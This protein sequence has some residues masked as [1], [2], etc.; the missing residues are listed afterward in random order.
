M[1]AK[2]LS[3]PEFLK[4]LHPKLQEIQKIA[5]SHNVKNRLLTLKYEGVN[6]KYIFRCENYHRVPVRYNNIKTR[7]SWC[8]ACAPKKFNQRRTFEEINAICMKKGGKYLGDT[9][10]T[11]K[12]KSTRRQRRGSFECH[13]G[14]RWNAL[15]NNIIRTKGGSWCPKCK[16]LPS[17]AKCRYILE[18]LF[19]EKFIKIQPNWLKYK[20]KNLELDG[21]NSELKLAFEYDGIHHTKNMYHDKM[22]Q[23]DTKENKESP[24]LKHQKA[25]DSHKNKI[26][27][28]LGIKMI[29]LSYKY[30]KG[31]SIP[32]VTKYIKKVLAEL[33]IVIPDRSN[34]TGGAISQEDFNEKF[35]TNYSKSALYLRRFKKLF[36][37]RKGKF[38]NPEQK[39]SDPNAKYNLICTHGHDF[40]ISYHGATRDDGRWCQTC[41]RERHKKLNE[42]NETAKIQNTPFKATSLRFGSIITIQCLEAKHETVIQ[43]GITLKKCPMCHPKYSEPDDEDEKVEIISTAVSPTKQKIIDRIGNRGILKHATI[44]KTGITGLKIECNHGHITHFNPAKLNSVKDNVNICSL[45]N[46]DSD[47]KIIPMTTKQIKYSVELVKNID[48]KLNEMGATR[49][50][51]TLKLFKRSQFI[52]IKCKNSHI[53]FKDASGILSKTKFKWCRKCNTANMKGKP[54]IGNEKS[55]STR[56]AKAVIRAKLADEEKDA[57]RVADRSEIVKKVTDIVASHE[58][59]IISEIPYA[60]SEKMTFLCEFKH[61]FT[62]NRTALLGKTKTWCK[63]CRN[64]KYSKTGNYIQDVKN[65]LE[66]KGATLVGEIPKLAKDPIHIKCTLGHDLKVSRSKLLGNIRWCTPCKKIGTDRKKLIQYTKEIMKILD[67]YGA[68]LIGEI[69]TTTAKK[70]EVECGKGHVFDTT[71]NA[72]IGNT[73]CKKCK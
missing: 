54:I 10:N 41:V 39:V 37:R 11:S 67:C 64:N 65:F 8:K 12:A 4:T 15:H 7:T 23:E 5:W 59:K 13:L 48:A 40:R 25:K 68:T 35:A 43:C 14:H 27:E 52:E 56:K 70:F 50:N 51:K 38:K 20:T 26:C 16:E 63:I 32:I 24:R 72:L 31:K 71:R 33:D 22:S 46:Y 45:C 17:E 44:T 3:N 66:S 28:K 53:F 18:H 62:L 47:G 42:W 21:Y 30:V 9:E 6:K 57:K 34:V 60:A 19:N 69:P 1:T 36:K 61:K 55:K 29:R 73:W 2:E 49:V 58:S